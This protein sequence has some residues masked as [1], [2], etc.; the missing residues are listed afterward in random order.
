MRRFYF[1]PQTRN[2]DEVSLSDEES[3]HI[4]KVLRLSAGEHVEL[5]DGQGAVF[6]AVIVGTGRR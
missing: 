3:H 5:L 1:D 6:R 4:V 2:G